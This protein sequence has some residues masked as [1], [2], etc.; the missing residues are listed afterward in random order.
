[1]I[2]NSD[3]TLYGLLQRGFNSSVKCNWI[4]NNTRDTEI[5]TERVTFRPGM[6][7][8]LTYGS[9]VIRKHADPLG[10]WHL[11]YE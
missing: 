9:E 6:S 5:E 11:K 2:S 1:M 4:Y 8:F 7:E 10:E 3:I